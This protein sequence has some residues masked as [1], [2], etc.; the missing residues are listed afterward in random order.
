VLKIARNNLGE[1]SSEQSLNRAVARTLEEVAARRREG[2]PR[3][4]LAG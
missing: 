3:A 4:I 2:Y 1:N